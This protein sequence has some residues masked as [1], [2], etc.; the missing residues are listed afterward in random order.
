MAEWP[1]TQY[2]ICE[3]SEGWMTIWLNRPEVRNALSNGVFEELHAVFSAVRRNA[4]IRGVTL[5]GKGGVFTAGGDLK[6][7]RDLFQGATPDRDEVE[8]S[9]RFYGEVYRYLDSMP[10][11]VVM[12]VEGAAIAGGLGLLCVADVVVVTAD[13]Q[14]AL[15]ETTIGI[16]PAQIAP[17]VA[18]AVGLKTAR[19][20]MLTASRFTGREAQQLG[21]ADFV[22]DTPADLDRVELDIRRKVLK[23]APR[24]VAVTKDLLLSSADL[25]DAALIDMAARGYTDCMLADEGREGVSSFFEKRPPSWVR[26]P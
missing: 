21:L 14:F 2:L 5:R 15:T 13:A 26:S 7:F 11:V 16:P 22:V 3:P 10:Q 18:R 1:D 12:L 25:D 9:S 23:C 24:A 20:L 8:R 17:L 6:M 4:A 19:R